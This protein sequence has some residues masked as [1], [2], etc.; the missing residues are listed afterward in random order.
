[1]VYADS[2]GQIFDHPYLEM[3]CDPG[4][5]P[6]PPTE[7]PVVPVPRGSDLYTLPGRQPYGRDPATGKIEMLDGPFHAVSTFLAPAWVRLSHP[8]FDTRTDA[9]T[10][11]LYAYAPMGYSQNQ[12]WTTAV[13]VDPEPRQDPWLFDIDAITANVRKRRAK[14]P[15]NRMIQ[16][17]E[18]CA[19]D[20]GCRAAQNYFIGRFEAPL[21]TSEGCNAQCVGCISLDPVNTTAA[22]ERI[23]KSPDASEI[24]EVALEH[25]ARVE[26]AVVSF[27]QGCEGEPLLRAKVLEDAIRLIRQHTTKGTI[28]LNS[29]ASLPKVVDKLC[30]AGLQSIRISMN[31]AVE[32]TYTAYYRPR[33][34]AFDDVRESAATVTRHGGFVSLN[35]LVFPGVSDLE[36]EVVALERF[37]QEGGVDMIQMR[38]LNIDPELYHNMLGTNGHG[39]GI[40]LVPMMERLR[41]KFPRLRYGYF[42]PPHQC[43]GDEPGPITVPQNR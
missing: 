18:R 31:S 19:L 17:L 7:L 37:I 23:V 6:Q 32:S 13:R 42:N 8:V 39:K 21:P 25:I 3:V 35:L 9:P 43:F 27:G 20:Y 29:N 10:L 1:M 30:S 16:Q 4:G 28:H 26:K 12:F 22:H 5:G 14:S 40:G 2:E 24:A 11:P 34:Y 41:A 33:N 38:N 15:Q 36:H